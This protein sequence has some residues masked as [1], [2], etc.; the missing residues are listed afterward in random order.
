MFKGKVPKFKIVNLTRDKNKSKVVH[1]LISGFLTEEKDKVEEWKD[2]ID[3]MEGC[4]VY[5]IT[6]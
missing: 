1:F 4:E 3:N 5:G 2:M 6:W